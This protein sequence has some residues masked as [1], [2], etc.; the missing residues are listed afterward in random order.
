MQYMDNFTDKR[1]AL[2]LRMMN[3]IGRYYFL[4]INC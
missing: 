3:I 1:N 2:D 4:N